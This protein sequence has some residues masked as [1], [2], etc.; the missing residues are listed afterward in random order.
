MIQA[1][2]H[3]TSHIGRGHQVTICFSPEEGTGEG[4]ICLKIRYDRN[5]FYEFSEAIAVISSMMLVLPDI[6]LLGER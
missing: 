3:K 4:F 6:W 1:S 2:N 5:I